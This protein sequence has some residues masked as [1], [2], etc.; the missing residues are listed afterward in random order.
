MP[1]LFCV[2]AQ[3]SGTRSRAVIPNQSDAISQST[4]ERGIVAAFVALAIQ[5]V[6][7]ADK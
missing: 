1:R 5:G 3:S 4:A 7:L 2:V 6:G